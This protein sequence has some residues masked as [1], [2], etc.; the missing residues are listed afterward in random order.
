MDGLRIDAVHALFD[1]S[2]VHFLEQLGLEVE[3]LSGEIGRPL[4]LI[5]ESDLNDPRLCR[6]RAAGGYGMHAQWNDDFHHALH[7]LLTGER[8]GYY[9]DFGRMTDVATALREGYVYAGRYSTFRG[10]SHGRPAHGLDGHAFVGFLQNHDQIGNRAL[11]ERSSHL[12]SRGRLA[13]GAAL[14]LTAPFVPM[15][16]QGEEWGASTPFQYFT[17]HGDARLARQVREGRRAEFA[18]FAWE[19]RAVPDP[20]A[21]STFARSK[22]DW[23]ESTRAPHRDVLEWHRSLIQLRRRMPALRDG[24][25]EAVAV[26]CDEAAGWLVVERRT[27]SVAC[28][29]AERTQRIPLRGA[30]HAI[31]LTSHPDAER[32]AGWVEVPA[33]SVVILAPAG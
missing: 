23:S 27:L 3:R 14:V 8:Q 11:G 28:N 32:G 24:R 15:L 9:A 20:Q 16:F 22:L 26:R 1:R 29:L 21:E 10:R 6:S 31:A 13:I 2:A 18:G 30:A 4:L 17:A 25:R 19:A 33:E 7:A 12:M 5:A